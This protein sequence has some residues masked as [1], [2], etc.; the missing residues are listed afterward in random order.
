MRLI[1]RR[2]AFAVMED[3]PDKPLEE[4]VHDTA[5]ELE[6]VLDMVCPPKKPRPSKAL[7]PELKETLSAISDFYGASCARL[8]MDWVVSS[9]DQKVIL[10][11]LREKIDGDP[12]LE[13]R[14]SVILKAIEGAV[15]DPWNQEKGLTSLSWICKTWSR[16]QQQAG[17]AKN[18]QNGAAIREWARGES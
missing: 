12:S 18:G 9:G 3:L 17:K 5:A 6:K 10:A 2:G 7:D 1:M 11:R 13:L 16:I 14:G 8:R 15:N 4:W